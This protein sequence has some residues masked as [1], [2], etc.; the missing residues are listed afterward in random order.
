MKITLTKKEV[1]AI[2]CSEVAGRVKF[3]ARVKLEED[4]NFY[5]NEYTFDLQPEEG[6]LN[7]IEDTPYEN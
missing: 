2:L 5:S 3:P 4:Y 1:I 6:L 7:C